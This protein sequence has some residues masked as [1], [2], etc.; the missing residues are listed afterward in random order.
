[1][2]KVLRRSVLVITERYRPEAFLVNDLVDEWVARGHE[3][4]V[5]T[6]VPSYPR[7]RLFPGF[8]NRFS[9]HEEDGATVTRLRTVLGYRRSVARKILNYLLFMIR[10]CAFA[11]RAARGVDA[12][13]VYHTGPLT[14]AA[15]LIPIKLLTGKRT[16]IWTQDVWPDA[17]FAYGFPDRGAFAVLLKAF[18]RLVYRFAD[19]VVVS[20]AGFVD[21]VRPYLRPGATARLVPQWVPREYERA[22][23]A[24]AR[25][26]GP[27]VL[28][29][30]TGNIGTMQNLEPVIRAFGRLPRGLATFYVVGDGSERSRLEALADRVAPGA[31]RFLG[32]V[33]QAEVKACIQACDF[34]VLSL[35]ADPL[36]GLTV[37]AKFQAYL[38]AGVPIV[39][40]ASGEVRRLVEDH[41]LGLCALPDDEGGILSALM[42]AI[43]SSDG[44]R[45][46]WRS[47]AG[48][49]LAQ[50]F[51]RGKAI[52]RLSSMTFDATKPYAN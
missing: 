42:K 32:S 36:V 38:A 29:V 18:V 33:A 5:L 21:R 11:P 19:E 52:E 39:A 14:Q 34:S 9:I 8:P 15:A 22:V 35:T 45:R 43:E 30:F 2:E 41:D 24:S 4:R 1:M 27:G 6:Q 26:D 31:V 25:F 3:V 13:F 50:F 51:D 44:D 17:V 7:D 23:P 47:N 49:L 16:V 40:I 37:P 12:V 10:A 28:F 48:S 20:S 46:R